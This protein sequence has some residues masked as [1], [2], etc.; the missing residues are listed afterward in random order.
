MLSEEEKTVNKDSLSRDLLSMPEGVIPD[1]P[2][3]KRL[4]LFVLCIGGL[5]LIALIVGV[6]LI[7]VYEETELNAVINLVTYAILFVLMFSIIVLDLPKFLPAF[8]SWKPYVFGI[9][10]AVAIVTF[11]IFYTS[12]VNLFYDYS[13][14]QN[15][16]SVRSVI[17]LYPVWSV[18]ILGFIGPLCEELAYRVGL[19]SSVNKIN[20]VLAYIVTI[21]VFAL[22]HFRFNGYIW[23]ELVNLPSYVVSGFVFTFLYDKF[24]FGASLTAHVSNNLYAVIVNIIV[25]FLVK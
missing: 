25:R 22:I 12:I 19:F 6:C 17:D 4:V 7:N 8:K 3:W 1:I 21:V 24:G 18:L 9:V 13:V 23:D 11:E 2:L 10:G 15:E 20:K 16:S 14:N 5:H